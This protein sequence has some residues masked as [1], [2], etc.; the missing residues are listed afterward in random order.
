MDFMLK[1]GLTIYLKLTPEQ[2]KNRL[3]E[4]KGERPLIKDL[5]K[6]QLLS[7][8]EEKLSEREKWYSQA[9]LIVKGNNLD[10]D[11]LHSLVRSRLRI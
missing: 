1:T 11:Q 6:R 8:I 10:T 7:F 3:S 5:D 2:L 4:S 9:E